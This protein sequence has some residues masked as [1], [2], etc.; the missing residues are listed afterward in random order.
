MNVWAAHEKFVVPSAGCRLSLPNLALARAL[1]QVKV[2][3]I[4]PN[5]AALQR[6][7]HM[8]EREHEI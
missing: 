3:A 8:L 5:R 7:Q 4:A 1:G 2:Q 6:A